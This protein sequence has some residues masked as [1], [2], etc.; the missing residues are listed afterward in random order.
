MPDAIEERVNELAAADGRYCV[1]TWDDRRWLIAQ[2]RSLRA[3]LAALE[4]ERCRLREEVRSFAD[5]LDFVGGTNPR[6]LREALRAGETDG[7]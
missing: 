5:D 6:R 4:V 3:Q 2:V 7:G 1:W